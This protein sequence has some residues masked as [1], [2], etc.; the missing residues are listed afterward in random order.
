MDPGGRDPDRR[1]AAY[2]EGSAGLRSGGQTL[3]PEGTR[4]ARDT[5]APVSS[6]WSGPFARGE[7][8][9]ESY[10]ITG[11]L[12]AG[13]MGVVYEAHDVWLNRTV[14]VKV[15]LVEDY[16]QSLR[17]EAQAMAA[18]HH[19][20]LVTIHAMGHHRGIEYLVMERVY[21]MTLEDRVDEA[22][23]AARP[24]P[25]EEVLDV[26]MAVTDA[27][28]AIH[29]AGVAHR[30]IKAANVMLTG[31]RVALTDFGLVTPEVAVRAGE[32]IAGSADYMAPELI[33]GNVQPGRGP[34]V[35]LYAL[36]VLGFELLAG[37]RPF[38]SEKL[39]A[40]LAAHL[41]KPPPDVRAFRGDVPEDLAEL[42][43][44]LMAKAPEQ[45]PESSEAVL[46]RL[47]ACRA[48]LAGVPEPAP[49]SAMIVDDEAAVA[50]I[51]RRNLCWALPRLAVEIE[52]DAD[53]ALDRIKRHPPDLLLVDLHMPGT[54]GV[55]LCMAI[56][57]LPERGQPA[58]V[59]MSAEASRADLD[60]LRSLGVLEFVAK[61]E[62]FVARVSDVVGDLRRQRRPRT[63]SLPPHS[64]RK[65]MRPR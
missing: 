43:R 53:T 52:T 56:R 29:R 19:P 38:A 11:I 65:P 6:S 14:A 10:E 9:G 34:L 25:I 4:E 7:V 46:W 41:Q 49:L 8:L 23:R 47:S 24:L 31:T 63:S 55:E 54:N 32:P 59:A 37:R 17:K 30:D 40:V 21:G 36:G 16:T 28:T 39:Q 57:A 27:I 42:L 15:P 13:G 35:D 51:L 5:P 18:V 60:V 26:L 58:V 64:T 33:L 12:G 45:R 48:A 22:W 2:G 61:D 20:N 62:A 44:E 3:A 50:E 1:T